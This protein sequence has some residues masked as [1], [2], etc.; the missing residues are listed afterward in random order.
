VMKENVT[1]SFYMFSLPQEN[2]QT[3][4]SKSTNQNQEHSPPVL[5]QW[6]D[7]YFHAEQSTFH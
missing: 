4:T 1:H 2:R 7:S 3:S 5:Q 6:K